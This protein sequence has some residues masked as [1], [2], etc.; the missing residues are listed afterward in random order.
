MAATYRVDEVAE[1][2]GLSPWSVRQAS[3]RRDT[4]LGVLALRVGR[5]II[6][7]RACV[8][9]L[10]GIDS[11]EPDGDGAPRPVPSDQDGSGGD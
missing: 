10:L 9:A 7:P 6:F 3:E 4:P 2:A 8:D 5:R 11:A 1:L